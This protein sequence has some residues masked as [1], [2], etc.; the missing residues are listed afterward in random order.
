M[1]SGNMATSVEVGTTQKTN[2]CVAMVTNLLG[3]QH[4]RTQSHGPLRRWA[5][6]RG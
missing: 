1:V 3:S 5:G 4:F 2:L 6:Q